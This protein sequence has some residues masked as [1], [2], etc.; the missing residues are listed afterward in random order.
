METFT[1]LEKPLRKST[2]KSEIYPLAIII[3]K[4]LKDLL[5][6][7]WKFKIFSKEYALNSTLI[8]LDIF[9]T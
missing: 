4:T 1:N 3:L 6:K 5:L 8:I 2:K 7:F 9:Q